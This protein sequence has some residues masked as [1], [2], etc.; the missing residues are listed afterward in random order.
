MFLQDLFRM[1]R[2]RRRRSAKRRNGQHGAEITKRLR[3][4]LDTTRLIPRDSNP[5]RKTS[6][7]DE[8]HSSDNES[9]TA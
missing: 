1:L 5:P 9:R 8:S 7:N 6:E 3:E 4:L 2:T